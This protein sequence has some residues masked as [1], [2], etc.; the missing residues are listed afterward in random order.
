MPQEVLPSLVTDMPVSVEASSRKD[1]AE[2]T[3]AGGN[4]SV[5]LMMQFQN[6]VQEEKPGLTLQPPSFPGPAQ[7]CPASC[8][9]QPKP[10][11]C[12][13]LRLYAILIYYMA[14][15]EKTQNVQFPASKMY[16]LLADVDSERHH[17][18]EAVPALK[19][20]LFW[21]AFKSEQDKS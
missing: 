14:S 16:V 8:S 4:L 9:E 21:E 15:G 10:G 18:N 12:E 2:E 19:R 11:D 3:A 7:S 20:F 5:L 6:H 13:C 1:T 17:A